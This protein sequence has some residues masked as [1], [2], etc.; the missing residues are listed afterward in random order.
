MTENPPSPTITLYVSYTSAT[1]LRAIDFFKRRS[2][3]FTVYDVS[4]NALAMEEMARISKQR[5]VPVIVI[6]DEVM[7]GF[8]MA[9]LRQILPLQARSQIA[10]GVSIATIK[11]TDNHPPGAFVGGVNAGSLAERAGIK[12]GDIITEMMQRPVLGTPDIHQMTGQ[13]IPGDAIS[14]TVWRAGRTLRLT[15]RA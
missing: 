13:I 12:K 14:L 3:E 5:H 7:I 2:I 1:C 8:D 9:R 11:E 6:D 10:L 4:E 15:I